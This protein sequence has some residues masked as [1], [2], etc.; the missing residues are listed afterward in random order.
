MKKTMNC[1]LLAVACAFAF[2]ADAASSVIDL[3]AKARHSSGTSL[4]AA[5]S[6]SCLKSCA[7]AAG[8]TSTGALSVGDIITFLLFDDIEIKITLAERMESPLGGETFIGTVSGYDGVKNAVV[9]QTA[10]GL[11]VDI[12]DFARNRAYTIVSDAGGVTVKE[13]DPSRET[14]TPTKPVDPGIRTGLAGASL[15]SASPRL[16]SDQPSTLVDVLV[17]Y[18]T[19]A[20][21]WARQN[22]GGITNF[23]TMAVQKMNTVLANCGFASTFRYRLVGVM[24][25][26]AT[27]GTDFDSVL[28]D[29]K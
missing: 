11:T 16:L 28:E 10:D 25:V 15:L 22:G 17:A 3:R 24:T 23:A 20:A 2:G 29:T 19:P 21:A 5:P 13:I 7:L 1:L 27:G 26:N 9:L 6:G 4:L 18:D 8:A 12:Q 14:V